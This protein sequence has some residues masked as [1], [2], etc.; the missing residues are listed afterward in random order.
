[1]F[2]PT[3]FPYVKIPTIKHGSYIF[4]VWILFRYFCYSFLF[5]HLLYP[6]SLPNRKLLL[7]RYLSCIF[8]VPFSPCINSLNADISHTRVLHL[9]HSNFNGG[10]DNFNIS[11]DVL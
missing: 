4:C 1:M 9:G 6:P 5:F 11:E 7:F 8:F 10:I 2:M 3:T